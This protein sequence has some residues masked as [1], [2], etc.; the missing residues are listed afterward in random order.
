MARR[1]ET[2]R[3]S[4]D[5]ALPE[6]L[7]GHPTLD[8]WATPDERAAVTD[9]M[10]WADLAARCSR[11]QADARREWGRERGLNLAEVFQLIAETRRRNRDE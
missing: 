2:V 8:D 6:S 3:T 9:E 4:E 5:D 11:R 7:L 1:R 10:A